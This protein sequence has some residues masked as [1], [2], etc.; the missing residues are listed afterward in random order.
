MF[1]SVSK[2]MFLFILKCRSKQFCHAYFKVPLSGHGHGHGQG[3]GQGHR[4][5][6]G[7]AQTL[8]LPQAHAQTP[9]PT[10]TWAQTQIWTWLGKDSFNGQIAK[11]KSVESY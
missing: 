1:V 10:K 3:Q 5:G 8:A 9:A 11:N 6:R 7:L 2:F 4:H